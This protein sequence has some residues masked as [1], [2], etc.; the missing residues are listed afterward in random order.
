MTG[1]WCTRGHC[2]YSA[3]RSRVFLHGC[4]T[5]PCN[6]AAEVPGPDAGAGATE[7]ERKGVPTADFGERGSGQVVAEKKPAEI[8]IA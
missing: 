6:A 5:P 4:P 1:A 2:S 7:L 3:H 8:D